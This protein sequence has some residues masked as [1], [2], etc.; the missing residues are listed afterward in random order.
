MVRTSLALALVISM[1][2]GAQAAAL[3]EM[4]R[5][6]LLAH[7]EMTSRWLLDEVSNLSAAQLDFRPSPE[8]W[9][10]SQVLDHLV[11]VGPVYW[12]DLQNAM[13]TEPQRPAGFSNDAD[14]LWY[15][16]D[17]TYREKAIPTELPK[18]QVRDLR[19]AL[20][21]YRKQHDQLVKYIQTTKDDLRSHLVRRQN[22][23]AYQ[24]ALL[25]STHEQRHILQIR[26]L[27]SHPK[28]PPK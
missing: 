9:S 13:K 18:G 14:I 1:T 23:D 28:F 25:I 22:S 15:G 3:T 11:V 26:E 6:R 24:W 21:A 5:Q 16:I 10:V 19:S 2:G 4:E 20:D 17:R 7:M 8:A 27:K 12:R